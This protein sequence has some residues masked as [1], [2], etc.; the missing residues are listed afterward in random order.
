VGEL[1][2]FGVFVGT[3]G[4]LMVVPLW[5][6][7]PRAG[8]NKYLSLLGAVPLAG[9]VLLWIVALKRWPGDEKVGA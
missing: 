7:M 6:L 2:L 8:M 1:L 3:S 4:V 9:T 5:F